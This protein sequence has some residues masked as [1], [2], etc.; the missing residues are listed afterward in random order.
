MNATKDIPIV[1]PPLNPKLWN[2]NAAANWSLLFSPAFGAFLHAKNWETLGNTEMARANWVWVKVTIAFLVL[3]IVPVESLAFNALCRLGGLALLLT[4]YFNLAKRQIQHVKKT[5]PATYERKGWTR[6]LLIGLGCIL[7]L[8][9][10]A[11]VVDTLVAAVTN[12]P[13]G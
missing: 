10:A 4:W 12:R 9:I 13:V 3:C 6:P 1:P 2:L 5:L 8:M 7:G 11:V